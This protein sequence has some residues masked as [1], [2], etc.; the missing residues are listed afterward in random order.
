MEF[1]H[2]NL[3]AVLQ[4]HQERGD[5]DQESK[6]YAESIDSSTSEHSD[7]VTPKVEVSTTYIIHFPA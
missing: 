2:V 6:I 7:V 4:E 1:T 5:D 3:A